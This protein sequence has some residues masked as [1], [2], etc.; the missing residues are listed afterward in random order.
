MLYRSIEFRVFV[1]EAERQL[2][3]LFHSIDRDA[4]GKLDPAE[5]QT[6]FRTAGL[7]ISNRRLSE[8]FQ[9]LDGNN[10]GYVSF[11]EWRYVQKI[12]LFKHG[13]CLCCVTACPR[14]LGRCCRSSPL[15]LVTSN[16]SCGARDGDCVDVA[17]PF[18]THM[19][20]LS[21][22]PGN[23]PDLEAHMYNIP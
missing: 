5:L 22:G 8:F 23:N 18:N 12:L 6:A 20:D 16:M 10:D 11:D 17:S 21:L 9:D 13:S 4:N 15:S 14:E 2:F 1:Q 7:S 19:T 3:Y